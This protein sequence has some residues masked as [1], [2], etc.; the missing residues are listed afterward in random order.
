MIIDPLAKSQ[1]QG[2]IFQVEISLK[3][4]KSFKIPSF[5]W[6]APSKVDY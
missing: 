2:K 5:N 3:D 6:K 4:T 1:V